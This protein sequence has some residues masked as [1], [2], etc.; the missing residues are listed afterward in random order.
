MVEIVALIRPNKFADTKN[1]L[2]ETGYPAYTC[3]K[4]MGRGR[5]PVSYKLADGTPM[6][7]NLV[8]KRMLS[9]VVPEE[10]EKKVID[11]ILEV[12]HTGNPGD[13]KIF[14]CP[15]EKTYHVRTRS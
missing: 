7:T 1:K 8:G 13:G 3:H 12:N 6:M 11:A 9:I 15:V 5:K 4:V 10:A 2:I 14:V